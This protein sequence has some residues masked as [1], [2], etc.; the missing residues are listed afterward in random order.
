M[1]ESIAVRLLAAV[2]ANEPSCFTAIGRVLVDTFPEVQWMRAAQLAVTM[3]PPRLAEDC[4]A[5]MKSVLAE[6]R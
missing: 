3:L 5:R 4:V 1:D 2:L 6:D